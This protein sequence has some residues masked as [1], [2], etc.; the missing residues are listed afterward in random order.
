MTGFRLGFACGPAGLIHAMTRIH[1]YSMLC[2]SIISQEAA[3]EAIRNGEG[4]MMEMREEYRQRRNFMVNAFNEI[5]LNC[6]LPHGSFYTFPSVQSTGLS[7]KEFATQLLQA[8]N[9]A[10]VPGNAFGNSGEGFIRCCFS[11]SFEKIE[12]SMERIA[13][14][15]TSTN[16]G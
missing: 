6:H 16:K 1:Q 11:T 15:V 3:L 14:F 2:A 9:V 7:S 10:A 13:R 12:L 4:P 5:G 8:E